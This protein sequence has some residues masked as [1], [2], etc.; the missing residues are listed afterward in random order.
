[1]SWNYQ[2]SVMMRESGY[3]LTT[4]DFPGSYLLRTVARMRDGA[5]IP[6]GQVSLSGPACAGACVLVRV[7]PLSGAASRARRQRGLVGLGQRLGLGQERR[8]LDFR[9]VRLFLRRWLRLDRGL[10]SPKQINP[11]DIP[12]SPDQGRIGVG[13]VGQG[14]CEPFSVGSS[15]TSRPWRYR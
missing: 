10:L 4:R 15:A 5:R 12:G 6:Q 9:G 8:L 3:E 13:I 11:C 1:M 7:C 2:S 14:S